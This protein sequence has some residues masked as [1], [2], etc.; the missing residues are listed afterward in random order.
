MSTYH[1]VIKTDTD[2]LSLLRGLKGE[3]NFQSISFESDIDIY[4]LISE[5][6][7]EGIRLVREKRRE[8][9]P[10]MI[11][12][13][14]PQLDFS[15]LSFDR[16]VRFTN[17]SFSVEVRFSDLVFKHGLDI[18]Y[19]CFS[20]EVNIRSVSALGLS[21]LVF[22]SSS[23]VVIINSQF[24]LEIRSLPAMEV[25][26]M[27]HI[28]NTVFLSGIN[29]S[30]AV[31]GGQL[32]FVGNTIK[33]TLDL[34]LSKLSSLNIVSSDSKQEKSTI[35]DLNCSEMECSGA[36]EVNRVSISGSLRGRGAVFSDSSFFIDVDISEKVY[37]TQC[38]F[39][40]EIIF[41]NVKVGK[42]LSFNSSVFHSRLNL[43]SCDI[44][45]AE[46]YFAQAKIHSD[47]WLGSHPGQAPLAFTGMISFQGA[48]ISSESLI[49]VYGLN[50]KG[51]SA[52]QLVFS[53][54]L[55]KGYLDIRDVFVTAISLDATIVL[56][57]IQDNNTL[58]AS[59]HDRPT[60]RL[61]K[62]ESK[63]VN[64]IISAVAYNKL[65][66]RLHRKEVGLRN[67]A[68]LAILTLNRLSNNYGTNWL[69]GVFF[70]FFGGL[71]FYMLFEL[72]RIDFAFFGESSTG[73]IL[74]DGRF[75]TGFIDYFWLPAGFKQLIEDGRLA[76]GAWGATLFIIGKVI[77]AYGI[78]QT[79]AAFRKY[80]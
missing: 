10:M 77:I 28:E 2:M 43:S 24:E 66:M 42:L 8:T 78:Y 63:K 76:G 27:L 79:V 44:Y 3:F 17:C 22:N 34:S 52:G 60:A 9:R 74:F 39:E 14:N 38:I 11:K 50:A 1:V 12:E 19:C 41:H 75:W 59:I 5:N 16:P 4:H 26:K 47:I 7:V 48:F 33:G 65:E 49:R 61:L 80:I 36:V 68:D 29:M 6:P 23:N 54:A 58:W 56:G 62:H 31:V 18:C 67:V 69:L 53:H 30:R 21:R 20:Q 57:N 46:V 70:T 55:I 15:A 71:L 72:F 13:L 51:N 45:S 73:F 64:N 35:E 32:N 40:K 37:L 25:E